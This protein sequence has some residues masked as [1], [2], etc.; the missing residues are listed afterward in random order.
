MIKLIIDRWRENRRS[1]TLLKLPGEILTTIYA[2]ALGGNTV[3]VFVQGG[4]IRMRLCKAAPG[5]DTRAASAI[6]TAT[7]HTEVAKF[8]LRHRKC[9]YR[10]VNHK[11]EEDWYL[12]V[13]D[14][15][16][17]HKSFWKDGKA[18]PFTLNTFVFASFD[19]FVAFTTS[20]KKD[21]DKNFLNDFQLENLT[22]LI[23]NTEYFTFKGI[24]HVVVPPLPRLESLTVFYEAYEYY[25]GSVTQKQFEGIHM[26]LDKVVE[27]FHGGKTKN[28]KVCLT[29]KDVFAITNA[30]N[31]WVFGAMHK[32]LEAKV[33]GAS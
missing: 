24:E 8:H 7:K 10:G 23:V 4:K 13:L 18:L 14:F 16:R 15:L 32:A 30:A 26:K 9:N 29:S 6:R 27:A 28:V 19:V 25:G 2:Y 22:S 5:A 3:H 12:G 1:A 31:P 33:L 17:T 21:F 11:K 20:V